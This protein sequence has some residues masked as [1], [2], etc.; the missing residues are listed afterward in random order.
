MKKKYQLT[1]N[2][3]Q[4]FF[5]ILVLIVGYRFYGFVR[6]YET[7]GETQYFGRPPSV[8]A[9]LPIS[10]LMSLK[11]M[12][13][14]GE[15]NDIH[16]AGLVIF[17]AILVI[18]VLFKRAFCSW[19]CPVGFLSEFLWK[20]GERLFGKNVR[21][22]VIVDGILRSLKYVILAFFSWVILVSMN[23]E[24]LRA[25]IYSPYNI[26]ADVKML[27]FFTDISRTSVIVIGV[28]IVLSV[29]FRNFWCRYLCPYGALL[30]VLSILSPFKV[31]RNPR[32]CTNCR[33]CSRVCPSFISVHSQRRVRSDECMACMACVEACPVDYTLDLKLPGKGLALSGYTLATLIIVVYFSF[34]GAGMVTG[35]WHNGVSVHEYMKRI[36][37]I[38]NPIYDHNR[39]KELRDRGL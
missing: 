37:D 5:T 18:A 2:C 28:L 38:H 17:I 8:E 20:S 7:N 39:G 27:M 33:K 11:Y 13:L 24:A 22:P 1:R 16:P 4:L 29:L 6:Y 34:V 36:S 35:N 15:I 25:F 9:F 12:V 30:G 21:M 26:V 10:S 31:T 3:I 23:A 32:T 19:I 14:T